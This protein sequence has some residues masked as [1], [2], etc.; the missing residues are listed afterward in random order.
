MIFLMLAA[1]A[2]ADVV[3]PKPD[4]VA[5]TIYRDTALTT[6]QLRQRRASDTSGLAM[7][8][9]TRTVDLP[10]GRTRLSFQGVADEI[11][12]A[13]AAVQGLPGHLVERNFDYDLLDP[14]SLIER[15]AGGPVTIRRTD[16]KTGQVTEEPAT[17]LTGPTGVLVRTSAGVEALGC[18][19]GPEALI[20]DHV[21]AGL[22]DKPTLSVIVDSPR[23]GRYTLTLTYLSVAVDWTAD[24]VA[25]L[26]PD[27]QTLDLTGWLTL[28]NRSGMTF[29]GAPT[30]VVAGHLNRVPPA[31]PDIAPRQ[32]SSECWPMGTTSDIEATSVAEEVPP[33]AMPPPPSPPPPMMAMMEMANRP[34]GG[35]V[36][37]VIQQQ[38]GDY[39]LYALAEPTT[40]AA[41]ETKQVR[42]LS[43]DNVRFE[44]LYVWRDDGAG[45]GGPSDPAPTT[46]TL[47]FENTAVNGLG[48][49]LP[50][51]A[52]SIR[53][54]QAD[55]GG[56]EVFVGADNVRDVP[57]N[58]PFE[59]TTGRAS[60]VVARQQ[61]TSQRTSGS[62]A[63]RRERTALEVTLAN[64]KSTP[65]IA[66]VRQS[67]SDARGFRVVSESVPHVLKHG[68]LVWRVTVPAGGEMTLTYAFDVAE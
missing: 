68:D 11:I 26:A 59:L 35:M 46:V 17:L 36:R 23:A 31:M 52:V 34:L 8:A 15:S 22:A 60:D 13:S 4:A 1:P 49:P 10:A 54:P 41:H 64:A 37:R 42:F 9:E 16:P 55:A 48:L 27:G 62:G 45:E 66:E 67:A 50:A 56:R 14:G 33:S 3:S 21:P 18:G 51:G 43:Q 44:K 20:F 29:E 57:L 28:A 32:V 6:R 5:V 25:R 12:P 61:I 40:L 53:Q 7:V 2:F 39:K 47:S 63:A 30:E 24:Y 65:V 58:E 38:L 19:A